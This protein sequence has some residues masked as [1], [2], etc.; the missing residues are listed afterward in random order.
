M[1]KAHEPAGELADFRDKQSRFEQT[2]HR[3]LQ[4]VADLNHAAVFDDTNYIFLHFI[5]SYLPV[6]LVGLVV[7]VILSAS[8]GSTSGEIN[9]LATVALIDIYKRYISRNASDGQYLLAS[10]LL[11]VFWTCFAVAFAAIGAR[12]FGALIERVN[13]VGSLFYGGLLGVFILAFF[14]KKVEGT[15]AFF[16]VLAG[17][18]AIFASAAFT[19]ISF[20]WYNV[21]GS[22]VVVSTGLLITLMRPSET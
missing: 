20:L 1:R 6:G 21:V 14:F 18:A 4:I 12:G 13:I 10:R 5:R 17:E 15:A 7:G 22:V 3:A 9:S 2:R 8:M 19:D 11:T 16:G